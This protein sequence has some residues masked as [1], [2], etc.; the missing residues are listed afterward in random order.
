[1]DEPRPARGARLDEL[2]EL[3]HGVRTE[4]QLREEAPTSAWVEST[5]AELRSGARPG[6]Y[7]PTATGGGVA[8]RSDR[9]PDSFAHVHVVTGPGSADRA[10]RLAQALLDAVPSS[11][12]SVTLGFT[13]LEA[14]EEA[15]VVRR[16][17]ERPGSTVVRRFDLERPL[18]P[19]DGEPLPPLP[20]GVGPVP[21]RDVTL[22]ALADLDVRA[23]RG[24]E[25]ALLIGSE[26]A[27]YRRVLEG[28]LAGEAGRFLDEASTTLYRADPPALLG[29]LLTCEK[30]PR[31]AVFL[32]FMVAPDAQRQGYGRYLLR[33]GFRAL[34]ALGYERVRLWVSEG[35]ASARRLY[36]SLGFGVVLATTIYRWDRPASSAHPQVA[37]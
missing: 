24:S 8:F 25:D 35:N 1:M 5:A 34:R 19:L 6:F 10:L 12:R 26:P 3:V 18:G 11:L 17:A 9:G 29:A 28:L 7:E 13:G 21:V 14:S 4:L 15:G 37:A 30:S 31:H 16:L 2:V 20:H 33:W 23:F 32:D 36:D 22:D 27:E